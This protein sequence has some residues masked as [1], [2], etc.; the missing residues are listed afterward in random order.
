MQQSACLPTGMFILWPLTAGRLARHHH[1]RLI[2]VSLRAQQFTHTHTHTHTYPR[3]WLT[4]V[5]ETDNAHNAFSP[6]KGREITLGAID[7]NV[8]KHCWDNCLAHHHPSQLCRCALCST[9]A[10]QLNTCSI[11]SPS[12]QRLNVILMWLR[13]S[14]AS[15]P[16]RFSSSPWRKLFHHASARRRSEKGR[17]DTAVQ[18]NK[19]WR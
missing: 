5:K 1:Y 2:T 12:E 13:V 15:S 7:C 9:V 17:V 11:W 10:W 8:I 4:A 14:P 18:G 6:R 19:L 3:S 16:Y